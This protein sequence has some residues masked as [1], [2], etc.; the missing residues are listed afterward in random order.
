M[1]FTISLLFIIFITIIISQFLI[2]PELQPVF[3][4]IAF[5]LFICYANIYTSIS[6]YIELRN[7][8]GL[9]GERGEP[10]LRGN[11][12]SDGVCVI[13]TGCDALQNCDELIENTIREYVSEY[14]VIRKKEEDGIALSET[15]KN[16]VESIN[17][18]KEILRNQCNTLPYSR[19]EFKK[20]IEESFKD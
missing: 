7:N 10:G 12:G 14:D 4:M 5:L 15:E 2:E 19:E 17:G 1:F 3:W 9:Q 16:T 13:N 6:Y 18:Y 11:K 8:P 20:I